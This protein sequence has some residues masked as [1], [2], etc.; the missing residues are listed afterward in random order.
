M[1]ARKFHPRYEN[2]DVESLTADERI[3]K[4]CLCLEDAAASRYPILHRL[5]PKQITVFRVLDT[6]IYHIF[7]YLIF[8][9]NMYCAFFEPVSFRESS[10]HEHK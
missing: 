10:T 6:K 7:I 4:A 9:A 3:Q 8:A 2:V 5:S 1:S